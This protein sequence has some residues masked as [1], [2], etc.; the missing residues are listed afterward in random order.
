MKNMNPREDEVLNRGVLKNMNPREY[1]VL[2][3]VKAFKGT[4]LISISN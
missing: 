3:R 4:A 2:N 1:E